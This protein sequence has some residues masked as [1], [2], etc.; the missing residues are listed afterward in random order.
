MASNDKWDKRFLS[1]AE[2]ISYWS[3]DPSTKCGAIIVDGNRIVS[4]GFNG[5]PKGCSDRDRHYNNREIKYERIIHAEQ[6]A[7][8][9]ATR[10]LK[11]CTIYTWPFPSCSRCT[12]L[13]IQ[14]GIT[15][16]VSPTVQCSNLADRWND[17]LEIAKQLCS[18]AEIELK[19][20]DMERW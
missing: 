11:D 14:S 10:S 7:L 6:N 1:L 16:I 12:A 3:K 9:F 18:E 19:I 17:N 20:Y 5:F 15:R 8:L 13:I 4:T 2:H